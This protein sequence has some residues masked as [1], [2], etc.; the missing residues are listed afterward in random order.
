[1]ILRCHNTGVHRLSEAVLPTRVV[2]GLAPEGGCSGE[3]KGVFPP[4]PLM[5]H[6]ISDA[7]A[8]ANVDPGDE[9]RRGGA[10][11]ADNGVPCVLCYC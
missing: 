11:S 2:L 8:A 4:S 7:G 3:K 6:G 10:R 5:R 9:W 1:M